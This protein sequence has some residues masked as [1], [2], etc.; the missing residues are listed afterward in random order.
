MTLVSLFESK[1][2]NVYNG[3]KYSQEGLDLKRLS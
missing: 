3:F 1:I 2:R